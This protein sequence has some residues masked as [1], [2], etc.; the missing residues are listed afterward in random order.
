MKYNN[1]N[2]SDLS[3]SS[4]LVRFHIAQFLKLSLKRLAFLSFALLIVPASVAY[5]GFFSFFGDLFGKDT[6]MIDRPVNSQNMNLLQASNSPDGEKGRG[7]ADVNVVGGT[8]LLADAG[9]SGALPDVDD[10]DEGQ[11]EISI[12]EVREGDSF[13]SI[14]KM[15]NVSVNTIL[16]ANNLNKKTTLKIGQ[17]LVILPVS[18]VSH[19][20]KKG[21]TLEKIAKLYKGDA[22][23]I[24]DFNGLENDTVLVAGSVVIIPDGEIAAAQPQVVRQAT[25]KLRGASGPAISGYF[26][27]PLEHYTK[28]QGLHG[29][30]GVDLATY[31]GA[32]IHAAADGDVIV[33][34]QGGYNGGYGNYVVIRHP[35][36][37]QTLY[38]HMQSTAVSQGQHV[39]QGQTVGYLGNTG[40]STGPHLHFE[41]RGARNPF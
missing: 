27:S 23:E 8:A 18:G 7:G 17:S 9:P 19:T 13:S 28:T 32:P 38:A 41:V 36:G 29:Y 16:W 14:A 25:S 39:S 10:V 2:N 5:A 3:S 21:D 1:S 15:Y 20:V 37:T 35:N 4:S 22:D 40:R 26:A 30:N 6:Q 12:Y 33:S 31:L 34:R 24:R 11:D